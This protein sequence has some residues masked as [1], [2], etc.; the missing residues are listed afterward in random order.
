[1]GIRKEIVLALSRWVPGAGASGEGQ[2]LIRHSLSSVR[3][4]G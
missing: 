2:A 3:L 4:E 1:M